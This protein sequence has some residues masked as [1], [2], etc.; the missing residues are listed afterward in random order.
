MPQAFIQV[1]I[2]VLYVY[3]PEHFPE[4]PPGFDMNLLPVISRVLKEHAGTP[5]VTVITGT[6]TH[7]KELDTAYTHL[8]L[9]YP[10]LQKATPDAGNLI[11]AELAAD[12]F[13]PES[14]RE[15]LSRHIEARE[16]G[17]RDIVR[18]RY[19]AAPGE[20]GGDEEAPA[21]EDEEAEAGEGTEAGTDETPD[22]S[23]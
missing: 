22:R 6:P 16:E 13:D 20:E 8:A 23:K 9:Q 2:P 19:G 3:D 11:L 21:D 1:A 15:H 18:S 10:N 4:E 7:V 12:N 14:V 17:V 5:N